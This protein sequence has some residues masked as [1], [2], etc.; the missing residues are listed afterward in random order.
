MSS[1][2]QHRAERIRHWFTDDVAEAG[3]LLADLRT[4]G[5]ELITRAAIPVDDGFPSGGGGSEGRGSSDLRDLSDV[6]VRRE[7]LEEHPEID[8]DPVRTHTSEMLVHVGHAIEALRRADAARAAAL[9][10]PAS[11]LGETREV[12]GCVN[13]DRFD[14][15]SPVHKRV[16]GLPSGGRCRACYEYRRRHD[17]RDAPEAIVRARPEVSG[18]RRR[19]RA[20]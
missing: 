10:V 6:V 19:V 18:R 14:V 5:P 1:K 9:R 11:E 2:A 7:W 17:G 12:P 4:M 20:A 3:R 16:D 15:Q 8:T 13:C